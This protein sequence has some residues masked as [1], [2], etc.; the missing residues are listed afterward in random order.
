MG[1]LS[2]LFPQ[3]GGGD[4]KRTVRFI[5]GTST[6][7]WTEADCD[8]LCDGTAD[9]VEIIA[10]IQAL[11]ST[12]GEVVILDGTYNITAPIVV[13]K[14]YVTLSGNGKATKL[15]R[16]FDG[17]SAAYGMVWITVD[18][19]TVRD[20]YIDGVK[21]IY[22]ASATYNNGIGVV[23]KSNSI[24]NVICSNNFGRGV[25]IS[26]VGSLI[27]ENNVVT[28][29]I[30]SNNGQVGILCG[31]G[32]NRAVGNILAGN[33]NVGINIVGGVA[34]GNVCSN[35][36]TG[37]SSSNSV[38][39]GNT[40]NNNNVYGIMARDNSSVVGNICNNNQSGITVNSSSHCVIEGNVC[41]QNSVANIIF[42]GANYN[43]VV[44][45]NCAVLSDDTTKPTYSIQLG[46]TT[47][48]Y[49]LIANNHLGTLNYASGGGTSNTFVNN[50]YN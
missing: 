6:A 28:G 29:S 8:Y 17:N 35:S 13:N 37:I 26:N 38:V 2:N 3:G 33:S 41:R 50:K 21:E 30:V 9:D 44:G 34:V 42:A 18:N 47:N 14:A 10:A 31:N 32:G 1:A 7:G 4:G 15:M 27:G 11:P 20:L 43:T 46:G 39:V 36:Y 49:N 40:C 48:S 19:C 24:A 12:G 16:G 23:G 25:Y 45:N 5:V 22:S